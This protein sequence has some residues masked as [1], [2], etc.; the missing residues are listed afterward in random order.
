[1]KQRIPDRS[2]PII[3][4]PMLLQSKL[5]SALKCC[6]NYKRYSL[7]YLQHSVKTNSTTLNR[8]KVCKSQNVPESAAHCCRCKVHTNTQIKVSLKTPQ[9]SIKQ[10][11]S[12][13]AAHSYARSP[14]IRLASWMSFGMIV[15]RLAWIAHRLVSSNNPTRYA[16]LA[17]YSFTQP[18][19]HSKLRIFSKLNIFSNK[20]R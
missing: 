3:H 9:I 15:T 14:R 16:S 20:Y 13:M 7:L 2:I 18:A 11:S 10:F 6:R 8:Q 17:S 1:M 12:W 5:N 4:L 19:N